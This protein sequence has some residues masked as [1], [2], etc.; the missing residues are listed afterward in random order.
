M[1]AHE[2]APDVRRLGLDHGHHGGWDHFWA[3]FRD[4]HKGVQDRESKA[5]KQMG[6]LGS[7]HNLD[8]PDRDLTVFLAG[9]P[10]MDAYLRDLYRAPE[11]AARDRAVMT[12][13]FQRV[14]T[15]AFAARGLVVA[16]DERS[17]HTTTTW[18]T[19]CLRTVKN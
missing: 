12:A 7:E 15:E 11:Y 6:S 8:L 19:R 17:P 16:Y 2:S 14:V 18:H 1:A 10:Q 3:R 9:T 4:L 13:L 5:M